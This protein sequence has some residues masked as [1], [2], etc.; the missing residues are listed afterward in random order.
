MK[1]IWNEK[2]IADSDNTISLEG[3]TYFP[4]KSVKKDYLTKNG[5]TYTCSWKGT[6]DYY[7]VTV[8]G[9]TAKG[10][11]FVYEEPSEEAQEIAGYYAFWRGVD[12]QE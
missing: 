1:A 5:E 10:A 6:C 8:D 7:D 4:S 3:M 2:V 11:A 12:I 9:K